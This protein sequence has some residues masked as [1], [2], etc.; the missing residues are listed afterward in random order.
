M[1]T[2][3]ISTDLD[4]PRP[5]GRVARLH[6]LTTAAI[7]AAATVLAFAQTGQLHGLARAAGQNPKTGGSFASLQKYLDN[8]QDAVIPLAIPAA[9]LGLIGGG[10]LYLVGSQRAQQLLGGVVLGLG[11]VLLS[12][13][14]IK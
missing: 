3:T 14:I 12:P 9:T 4:T 6:Q 5:S 1:Q 11:L 13:E 8:L 10:I 2:R 7:L